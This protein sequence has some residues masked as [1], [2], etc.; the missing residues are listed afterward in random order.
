MTATETPEYGKLRIDSSNDMIR[1]DARWGDREYEQAAWHIRQAGFARQRMGQIAY[2]DGRFDR[3]AADWLSAAACFYLVPDLSR[4]R[5]CVDLVRSLNRDGRI[6]A[7]RKDIYAAL[8]EREEQVREL[9]KR[10]A[11]FW[12]GYQKLSD[13][14]QPAGRQSLDYLL[15]QIRSFPGFDFLHAAISSLALQRGDR[16]LAEK[17]LEWARR[18]NPASPHLAAL[19]VSQLFHFGES[20]RA[21]QV[22]RE[23]LGRHPNFGPLRYLAAQAIA[24][25]AGPNADTRTQRDYEEA[26]RILEPLLDGDSLDPVERLKGLSFAAELY[27]GLGEQEKRDELLLRCKALANAIPSPADDRTVENRVLS[28]LARLAA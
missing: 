13:P 25:R 5:E 14:H 20:E 23:L 11:T 4:M 17:S 16:S 28:D 6:S 2:D 1:Y 9:E 15:D 26:L 21:A 24:F 18:F 27:R 8:E 12:E 7:E 22:A 3:A 19:S 10:F